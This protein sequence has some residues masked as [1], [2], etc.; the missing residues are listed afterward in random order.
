MDFL[1]RKCCA[2]CR[3][4]RCFDIGMRINDDENAV[5]RGRKRKDSKSKER[6]IKDEINAQIEHSIKKEVQP[7]ETEINNNDISP[8]VSDDSIMESDLNLTQY[9][10][11]QI[12]ALLAYCSE[13]PEEDTLPCSPA[14]MSSA[15][16]VNLFSGYALLCVRFCKNNATFNSLENET[17]FKLLKPFTFDCLAIRSCYFYRVD[18]ETFELYEDESAKNCVELKAWEFYRQELKETLPLAEEVKQIYTDF[19]M[20][21]ENDIKIRQM[22]TIISLFKRSDET[23]PESIR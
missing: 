21:M 7:D 3:L 12:D 18:S 16:F 10:K 19:K 20:L 23:F 11:G 15:R 2:Y 13:Y 8:Q 1:T 17:Q 4:I 9:E 22:M 5:T 14:T 6:K